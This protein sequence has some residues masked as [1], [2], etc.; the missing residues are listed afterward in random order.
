MTLGEQVAIW[1]GLGLTGLGIFAGF[2]RVWTL[3]QAKTRQNSK[4]Y[5][6]LKNTIHETFDNFTSALE[7]LDS[8]MD[9]VERGVRAQRIKHARLEEKVRLMLLLPCVKSK[10]EQV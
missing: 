10:N 2:I 7:K 5:I 6:E 3:N 9:K 1:L 4:E 8:K